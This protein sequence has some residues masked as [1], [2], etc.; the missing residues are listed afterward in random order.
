[1]TKIGGVIKDISGERE[2]L[3]KA[4]DAAYEFLC[5]IKDDEKFFKDVLKHIT[6]TAYKWV[7]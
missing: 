6:T 3:A 5:L 2:T 7:I 4:K 1:M